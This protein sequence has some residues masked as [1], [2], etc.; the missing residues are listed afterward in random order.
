MI[1]TSAS[2]N[3]RSR[4]GNGF[5][6]LAVLQK[7][8]HPCTTYPSPHTY[9]IING[10][11]HADV[12]ASLSFIHFSRAYS[13]SLYH[14]IFLCLYPRLCAANTTRRITDAMWF[15]LFLFSF[16]LSF[17]PSRLFSSDGIPRCDGRWRCTT[18]LSIC[19]TANIPIS[20]LYPL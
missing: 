14:F 19:F 3:S 6:A 15:L 7:L 5:A 11:I 4:T 2:T 20:G 13:P 18:T 12:C 9:S 10:M 17:L 8:G 16:Y 1:T